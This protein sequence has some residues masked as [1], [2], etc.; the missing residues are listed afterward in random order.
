M[1]NTSLVSWIS[2]NTSVMLDNLSIDGKV[3]KIIG[4]FIYP[5]LK[6][7]INLRFVLKYSKLYQMNR[8]LRARVCVCVCAYVSKLFFSIFMSVRDTVL[9]EKSK[10]FFL[11]FILLLVFRI[12][13]IIEL[14][15]YL[16]IVAKLSSSVHGVWLKNCLVLW[17]LN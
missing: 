16:I 8:I 10:S 17:D 15:W 6:A 14:F 7:K 5:N 9:K 3:D 2:L 13:L 11:C 4:F 12:I 1:F